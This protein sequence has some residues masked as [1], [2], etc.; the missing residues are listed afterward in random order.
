MNQETEKTPVVAYV[1]VS[2]EKQVREGNGLDAQIAG[3]EDYCQRMNYEISEWFIDKAQ[4]RKN[5]E[6]KEFQRMFKDI[7]NGYI[8]KVLVYKRDRIIGNVIDLIQVIETIVKVY[9]CAVETVQDGTIDW[10][11]ANDKFTQIVLSAKDNLELE[12]ISERTRDGLRASAYKGNFVRGG[13][14]PLGFRRCTRGESKKAIEPIPDMIEDIN[15]IFDLLASGRFAINNIY[16]HLNS[17]KHL[18]KCDW[19]EQKIRRM[20]RNPIYAGVLKTTYIE[21]ENH[22]PGIVDEGLYKQAN[23]KVGERN[24][25]PHHYYEIPNIFECE[26]GLKMRVESVYKNRGKPNEKI[27]Q[28]YRCFGC[29]LRAVY[30]EI[31][32]ELYEVINKVL[33]NKL[34]ITTQTNKERRVQRRKNDLKV[35]E[36]QYLNG[37]ISDVYYYEKRSEILR[38]LDDYEKKIENEKTVIE[39]FNYYEKKE[40]LESNIKKAI[41]GRLKSGKVTVKYISYLKNDFEYSVE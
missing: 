5:L 21:I 1:R 39:N 12:Q 14:I 22:S 25:P 28:Y 27:Y 10:R 40:Y 36:S 24:H 29:G 30:S 26:C 6:R 35:L 17:K 20:I 37:N 19:N 2:T 13:P 16:H 15:Y 4:S 7:V 41:L 18:G 32:H 23:E 11:N 31:N 8:D 33:S 38:L 9:G 34:R 3:I